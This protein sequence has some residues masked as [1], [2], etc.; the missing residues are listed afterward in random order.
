MEDIP[1]ATEEE[2]SEWCKQIFREKV[3]Y[4]DFFDPYGYTL[5]LVVCLLY[6]LTMFNVPVMTI[7]CR[8]LEMIAEIIDFAFHNVLKK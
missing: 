8:N 3:R 2:T 4:T 1:H 7:S 6:H 5:N